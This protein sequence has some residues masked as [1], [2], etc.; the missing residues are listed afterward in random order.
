MDRAFVDDPTLRD[1][2][3]AAPAARGESCRS[4]V[5]FV[6]DRP[7]HDFRYAIDSS[8]VRR[9]LDYRPAVR[10]EEGLRTTV[11]WYLDHEPWW[12]AVMDGS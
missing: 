12:R 8:K 3:P 9:E 6:R 7:A 4:L 11:R 2:F 10:F 5:T 1:R